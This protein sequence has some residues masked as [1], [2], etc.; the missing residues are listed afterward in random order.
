MGGGGAIGLVTMC[1]RVFSMKAPMHHTSDGG[2]HHV[3]T[4][5]RASKYLAT[6]RASLSHYP[7]LYIVFYV[8]KHPRDLGIFIIFN[9]KGKYG[10]K[11]GFLKFLQ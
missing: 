10:M 9:F 4:R 8:A 2:K 11:L 7:F 5:S 1:I 3:A 6:S